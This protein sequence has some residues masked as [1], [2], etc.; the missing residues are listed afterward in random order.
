[1]HRKAWL[2]IFLAAQAWPQKTIFID[3]SGPWRVNVRDDARFAVELRT[4]QTCAKA[5]YA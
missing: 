1:M 5:A 3:L 2:A 4:G